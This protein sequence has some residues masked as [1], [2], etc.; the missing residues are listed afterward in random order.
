[1]KSWFFVR[2]HMAATCLVFTIASCYSC[3]AP[4]ILPFA[5]CYH[6][7]NYI[8]QKYKLLYVHTLDFETHG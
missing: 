1:M 4:L 5:F 7:I 8:V 6:A 3:I 2:Y